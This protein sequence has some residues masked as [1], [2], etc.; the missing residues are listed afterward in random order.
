MI[1]N[2]VNKKVA[3][4]ITRLIHGGADENTI[5]SC[6][7]LKKR[8]WDV[9]LIIGK[10]CSRNL[11]CLVKNGIKVIQINSMIRNLSLMNDFKS[12]YSVYKYCKLHKPLIVH[13]HTAKAG[14]IGRI[15]AWLGGVPIIIH[16]VHGSPFDS[17]NNKYKQNL[18]IFIEKLT[19]KLNNHYISVGEDIFKKYCSQLNIINKPFTVVRSAFNVENYSISTKERKEFRNK[20]GYQED[21]IVIGVI[22][23]VAPQ[24]GYE[25]YVKLALRLLQHDNRFKFLSIGRFDDSAYSQKIKSMLCGKNTE[26][27]KFVGQVEPIDVPKYIA[28]MDIIVHTALWEGLPRA[29]VEALVSNKPVISFDVDGIK[30]VIKPSVNGFIIPIGDVEAMFHKVLLLVNSITIKEFN[31]NAIKINKDLRKEFSINK[32]IDDLE[33]VYWKM[34]NNYGLN[35]KNKAL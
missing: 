3:H 35:R 21:D 17:I 16:G 18:L 28:A 32:M 7:E 34:L 9:D 24:K 27:I 1:D 15:G 22:G 33:S 29:V 6:I 2:I 25:Y 11:N 4:I 19:C 10:E 12:I 14:V 31:H 26:S 8:G 20:L 5:I 30:E 13:T 23:R